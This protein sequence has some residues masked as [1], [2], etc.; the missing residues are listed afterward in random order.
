MDRVALRRVVTLVVPLV[1][2]ELREQVR[3]EAERLLPEGVVDDERQGFPLPLDLHRPERIGR[4]RVALAVLVDVRG[5]DP[6][7]GHR[8]RPEVDADEMAV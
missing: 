7:R 8:Q 3:V 6:V 1:D 4:A 2:G 5:A